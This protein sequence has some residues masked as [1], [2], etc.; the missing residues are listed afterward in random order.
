M[1]ARCTTSSSRRIPALSPPALP[2]PIPLRPSTSPTTPS[3]MSLAVH[4][5]ASHAG[6]GGSWA[7]NVYT[8]QTAGTWTVTGTYWR[9]H[10]YCQ[11]DCQR[12]STAPHR[13]LARHRHHHRR[14][15]PDLHRPVLRPV[16][17]PHRRCHRQHRLLHRGRRRGQLG[18]QCLYLADCRH[19]DRHRHVPCTYTDTASL[20]VNAGALDH[21]VISPDTA[22][23]TAGST[24]TYTAQSFDQFNNLIADISSYHRLQHHAGAGGS[25]NGNIYT[26]AK[27]RH[28]DRHRHLHWTHRHC[29]P[30]RQRRSAA[31]HRH[32]SRHRYCH[33]R[34]HP[35]ATPPSPSTSSITSLPMSPAAP[36]SPYSPAPA[37]AGPPTSIPRQ[38]AGTWTV[39]GTYSAHL[40][41]GHAH[42]QCRG[43][44]PHR[45][46]SGQR[47]PSLPAT[48]RLTPLSPSTSSTTPSP[49]L[50]AARPSPYDAGAG[51]G[52]AAN[53]YTSANRRHLDGHRHLPYHI[54]RHCQSDRHCVRLHRHRHITGHPA[55]SPRVAPRPIP[56]WPTTISATTVDVTAS[57][58]FSIDVGAGGSLGR[59]RLH[60]S[61]GRHLDGHRHL[62]RTHRYRQ[63][64]RQRWPAAPHHRS[65]R[66]APPSLPA[67]PRPTPPS[68]STS[69]TTSSPTSPAARPSASHSRRW[70]AGP[71]TSIL[72]PRLAF[73]RSP[74]PIRGTTDTATLGVAAGAAPH[75]HLTGQRHHHR[76]QSPD[77]HRSR[78]STSSTTPSAMSPPAPPSPSTP[79]LVGSWATNV[80]TSARGWHLDRHRHLHRTVTD[81]ASL[82]VNA[83][84]LH[85]II[86]SPDSA[87]ITA[88]NAQ[89]YTAQSFDQFDNPIAD[90]TGTTISP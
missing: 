59:Q 37:A 73:G 74:A 58:V 2:R 13:H 79:A 49:M 24:Q 71:P 54:H 62:H 25:W 32:L 88:G 89:P 56:S 38:T 36:P 85:H 52:W 21:I 63:P 33:S 42:R 41:Y 16:Q 72:L 53:V 10:R 64:D 11:P 7:A 22:T 4:S 60:F 30:D 31:P 43:A 9:H 8:S 3:A 34:R 65:L 61:Q 19:L 50:P 47:A 67:T 70:Q 20:T 5:S 28:L 83:G 23:I 55:L 90:I 66:T 57:T 44:A 26:S 87:T 15:H 14:Q 86:I 12:R 18:R 78:P 40:R 69:S 81:T 29:H 82:T 76:R 6:A 39:T 84:P 77:L 46:L 35:D 45:H 1:P 68:P 80:Y 48:P 51:G 17:Q 75:R 27:R